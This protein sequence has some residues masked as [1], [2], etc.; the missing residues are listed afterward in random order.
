M[1]QEHIHNTHQK[2]Y[3]A[4]TLSGIGLCALLCVVLLLWVYMLPLSPRSFAVASAL[5]MPV[6]KVGSDFVSVS[7]LQKVSSIPK[8]LTNTTVGV[9]FTAYT[10]TQKFSGLLEKYSVTKVVS[11][12]HDL[13]PETTLKVWWVG[14]S[15]LNPRYAL[16]QRLENDMAQ[17]ISV[18]DLAS[19]YSDDDATKLFGGDAG[20]VDPAAVVPEFRAGLA[21]LRKDSFAIIPTRNGLEVV[22]VVD[23]I[24]NSEK[25]TVYHIQHIFLQ[26]QGFNTWLRGQQDSVSAELYIK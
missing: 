18:T 13:D 20:F 24:Q 26:E 2:K 8:A 10:N 21:A 1:Q 19:Q 9:Y 7:D 3:V 22:H 23:A 17:G 15:K 12:A 6:G 4:I 11:S 25:R 16:A 14:N 5:H